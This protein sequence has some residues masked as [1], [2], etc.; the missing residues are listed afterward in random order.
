MAFHAMLLKFQE[1][2][3]RVNGIIG[4]KNYFTK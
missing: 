2:Y 3:S 1:N 4:I